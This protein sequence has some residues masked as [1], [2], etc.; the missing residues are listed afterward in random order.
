MG[1]EEGSGKRLRGGRDSPPRPES[2]GESIGNEGTDGENTWA[3]GD[4]IMAVGEKVRGPALPGEERRYLERLMED[5]G[6]RRCLGKP[7]GGKKR[8]SGN[9]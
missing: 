8:E 1:P 9:I 3:L 5:C 4:P 7:P 6:L 2:V